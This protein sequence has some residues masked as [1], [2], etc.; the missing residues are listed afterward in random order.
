MYQN[1]N[2]SKQKS[3]ITTVDVCTVLA[4]IAMWAYMFISLAHN[5]IRGYVFVIFILIHISLSIS[6]HYGQDKDFTRVLNIVGIFFGVLFI[7]M[8]VSI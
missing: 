3:K 2:P 1:K 7:L 5:I 4:T 6:N 8:S